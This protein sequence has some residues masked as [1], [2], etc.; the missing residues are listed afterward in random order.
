[1]FSADDN[2]VVSTTTCP[3]R[4]RFQFVGVDTATTV[5]TGG[6]EADAPRVSFRENTP[7]PGLKLAETVALTPFARCDSSAQPFFIVFSR[8]WMLGANAPRVLFR[9]NTPSPG[10]EPGTTSLTARC[11]TI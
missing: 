11:S 6:L 3:C 4:H 10:L 7:S 2:P 1:M 8:R 5:A 9:E